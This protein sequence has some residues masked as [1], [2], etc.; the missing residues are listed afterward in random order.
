MCLNLDLTFNSFITDIPSLR[1]VKL[2]SDEVVC[3]HQIL[4]SSATTTLTSLLGRSSL[5]EE[6][7]LSLGLGTSA[8]TNLTTF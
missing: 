2:T 4:V 6:E 5:V 8:L 1:D 7:T 3:R